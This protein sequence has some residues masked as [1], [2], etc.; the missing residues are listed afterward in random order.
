ML[1]VMRKHTR[2]LSLIWA[3][4]RLAVSLSFFAITSGC[5]IAPGNEAA[6]LRKMQ[7]SIA[8][9]VKAGGDERVPENIAVQ[10]ITAQLIIDKEKSRRQQAISSMPSPSPDASN[11][12]IRGALDLNPKPMDYRVGAGDILTITVWDHPELTTPAGQYRST[13]ESGTLIAEDGTIFYPYVGVVNVQ[14]KSL[15]EI[16]QILSSRLARYIERVQLDVRVSAFRSK[17][18]Y[19]VGEVTRPGLQEINDLRMT[20]VEAVN[21]AGGVTADADFSQILLTRAGTIYRVDLQAL[22]ENGATW[23]NLPLEPGD[24]VNVPDRQQNKIFVLGE[25]AKPGSYLMNKRRSTLAE[26]LS[27]AGFV[28][29]TSSDPKWI[30]VMRG[31]LDRPEIFH[32]DAKSPDALI[33]ADQFPLQARDIVYVD[34]AEVARWNRVI[35]NILPTAT[36]LNNLGTSRYPLFGGEKTLN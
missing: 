1:D 36:I 12:A 16:R 32:L 14:G 6:S 13:Q 10:S 31:T 9:P 11:I 27:E 22:Y 3:S 20:M 30:F 29:Q 34:A 5:I 19:V 21:R 8:F 33:L 28:N 25:V 24:V 7:S 18:I 23:Q 35:T 26:A 4:S 2:L 15:T 17:R